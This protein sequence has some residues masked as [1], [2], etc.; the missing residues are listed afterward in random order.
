LVAIVFVVA[1]LIQVRATSLEDLLRKSD[2]V[3]LASAI[4]WSIVDA[5][6]LDVAL[7]IH[8]KPVRGSLADSVLP[9]RVRVR[10]SDRMGPFR[11]VQTG[12][13]FLA[14][15]GDLWI[16]HAAAPGKPAS[17]SD[18]VLPAAA[19]EFQ[20]DTDE[21]GL[22]EIAARAM[23]GVSRPKEAWDRRHWVN[24]LDSPAIRS[25]FE[26]WREAKDPKVSAIGTS[27]LLERGDLKTI[28]LVHGEP[29]RLAGMAG[30]D[31]SMI[32][33]SISQA[34]R[35]E[36]SAAIEALSGLA[37]DSKQNS[38]MRAAAAHA[39][40]MI[41]N[42]EALGSLAALLDDPAIELRQEGCIGLGMFA[43]G[44][45]VQSRR[46]ANAQGHLNNGTSSK[47]RTP[48]VAVYLGFDR[49]REAEFVAFWKDWWRKYRSDFQ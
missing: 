45:P 28:Q 46:F 31:R 4:G 38:E 15:H 24:G 27:A 21:P 44:M 41:H 14:R 13:W 42:A 2:S 30:E 48:E 37:L 10:H 32:L 20:R 18:Y 49:D 43:N 36:D 34:F 33:I 3:V 35:N 39:L 1:C 22:L 6:S 8:G 47:Y 7:R 26:R 25:A 11:E 19:E 12:L 23:K 9:V 40:A 16:A 29:D 5:E 17:V